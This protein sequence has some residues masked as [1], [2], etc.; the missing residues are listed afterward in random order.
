M[1]YAVQVVH[2]GAS[3]LKTQRDSTKIGRYLQKINVYFLQN[4]PFSIY[5]EKVK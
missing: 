2:L 4:V 3:I 5:I 1:K